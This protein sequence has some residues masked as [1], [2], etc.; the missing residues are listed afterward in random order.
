MSSWTSQW[1][2][3]VIS[4]LRFGFVSIGLRD[5][6]TL[7]RVSDPGS[8]R[9]GER[10]RPVHPLN[11]IIPQG[12]VC[13]RRV[14]HYHTPYGYATWHLM[15]VIS[16]ETRLKT[17]RAYRSSRFSFPLARHGGFVGVLVIMRRIRVIVPVLSIILSRGRYERK[18]TECYDC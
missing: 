11:F 15:F 1:H 7:H 5:G 2:H 13:L 14:P 9:T 4:E 18:G 16:L 17:R 12:Y 6:P 3:P 10:F 8:G